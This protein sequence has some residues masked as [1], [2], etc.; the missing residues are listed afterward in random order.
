[1][2]FR[3]GVVGRFHLAPPIMHDGCVFIVPICQNLFP[4]SQ[5]RH[6]STNVSSSVVRSH[7]CSEQ[8]PDAGGQSH[9]QG[10]PERHTYRAHCYTRAA[11]ACRQRTQKRQEQQ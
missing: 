4:K 8:G 1:M 10:T 11:S 5:F 9:R 7:Y 3:D 6:P 2:F